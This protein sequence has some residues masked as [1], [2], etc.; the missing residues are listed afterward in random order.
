MKVREVWVDN[1]KVIACLLVV[2]GHFF[3][4]M[5]KSNIMETNYVIE[6]YEKTIYYFHVPLFFICSGYLYMKLTKISTLNDWITNI[7]KKLMNLGIPYFIFSTVTLLIK[8]MF[9]SAVNVK[10]KGILETLFIEPTA[11]YWYLYVLFFIFLITPVFKSKKD[12]TIGIYI[13]LIMKILSI[14]LESNNIHYIYFIDKLIS[15]EIWFV[16]GMFI[17]K[18]E[19]TKK[20]NKKTS[21]LFLLFLALSIFVFIY[22][23]NYFVSAFLLGLIACISIISIIYRKFINN[24]QS[25]LFKI[26]AKYTL[27]IFLMH[28][29]FAAAIRILLLKMGINNWFIHCSFGLV[30]SIVGPILAA[31]IMN[32][33][34]WTIFILYPNKILRI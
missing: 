32:R 4:S 5:T 29:I 13:A 14:Y 26:L 34:K 7:F 33:C 21:M 31:Q 16:L 28:T 10:E 24:Q 20:L 17:Y 18:H 27:P 1:V 9:S 2:L 12:V 22:L 19:I 15:N 3:Q 11:P 8:G 30:I 25:K 23:D 6:W